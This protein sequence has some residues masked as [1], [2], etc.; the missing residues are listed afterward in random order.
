MG[1]LINELW[2]IFF[3]IDKAIAPLREYFEVEIDEIILK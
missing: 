3:R 1:S 2:L